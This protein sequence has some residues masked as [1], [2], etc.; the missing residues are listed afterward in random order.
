[1]RVS[2]PTKTTDAV[3]DNAGFAGRLV[4]FDR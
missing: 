3:V 1:L 4:T 2:R